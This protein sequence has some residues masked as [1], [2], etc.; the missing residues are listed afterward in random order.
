MT[1]LLSPLMSAILPILSIAV[2]GYALSKTRSIDAEPLATVSI[3]VLLPALVFYSLATSEI[4]AA[5]TVTF[6]VGAMVFTVAI[7]AVAEGIGRAGNN[8]DPALNG[9]V[10]SSSF[11][12]VGN[13]GIPFM[14]FAFGT[15]GRSAAV[16]FV[17]GQAVLMY[18]MGVYVA[19]REGTASWHKPVMNIFRL[20]ML[21]AT[22]AG[23][24][25]RYFDVVPPLDRRS[26][27][28]SN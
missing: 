22:V 17:I 2:V 21:Y 25:I 26:C 3:Y 18:T 13:F 20:P 15:L 10:L 12:N 6:I 19:S 23:V 4:T 9:L 24:L 27:R 28:R 16:L 14:V 11:P 8:S 7:A 5:T 1:S